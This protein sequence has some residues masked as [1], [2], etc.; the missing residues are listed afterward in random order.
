M[1]IR[2]TSK[3]NIVVA[4]LLLL[5]GWQQ[6]L[7]DELQDLEDGLNVLNILGFDNEGDE[8]EVDI[9]AASFDY[10]TTVDEKILGY[11]RLRSVSNLSMLAAVK[12]YFRWYEVFIVLR[13]LNSRRS[14]IANHTVPQIDLRLLASLI[15]RSEKVLLSMDAPTLLT[16]IAI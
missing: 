11:F 9:C 14:G 12:V 3:I 10:L 7:A 2:L 8:Q 13:I 16:Q 6:S 4:A 1:N 5:V 15:T